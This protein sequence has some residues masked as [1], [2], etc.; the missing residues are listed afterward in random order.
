MA[1]LRFSYNKNEQ[2]MKNMMHVEQEQPWKREEAFNV[3]L[4]ALFPRLSDEGLDF[5]AGEEVA[6]PAPGWVRDGDAPT[7]PLVTTGESGA[8]GPEPHVRKEA[9][10]TWGLRAPS[11][12]G[13]FRAQCSAQ[14]QL[15]ELLRRELHLMFSTWKQ[16]F[17]IQKG[18]HPKYPRMVSEETKCGPSMKNVLGLKRL[19]Y[20]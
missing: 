3:A 19:H 20:G 9:G 18:T 14:A 11:K 4:T 17:L 6:A 5:H 2:Q 15:K 10:V 7:A 1:I 8:L 12:H 13:R 16:V